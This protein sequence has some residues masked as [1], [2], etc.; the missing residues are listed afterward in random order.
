MD[1]GLIP[2]TKRIGHLLGKGIKTKGF[3]I[4]KGN[5]TKEITPRVAGLFSYINREYKADQ[6]ALY[7]L[8]VVHNIFNS[9]HKINLRLS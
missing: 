9:C 4:C 3:L 5:P 8:I 2:S 7:D 1:K 6:L